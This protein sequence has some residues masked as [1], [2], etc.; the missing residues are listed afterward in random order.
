LYETGRCDH[1]AGLEVVQRSS[2]VALA[3][4][5]PGADTAKELRELRRG[6]LDAWRRRVGHRRLEKLALTATPSIAAR[7]LAIVPL[8]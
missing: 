5:P 4:P 6:D 3:P 1:P 8:G 7:V 2:L